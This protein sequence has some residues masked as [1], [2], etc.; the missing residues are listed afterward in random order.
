MTDQFQDSAEMEPGAKR[1]L[2][3]DDGAGR[4]PDGWKSVVGTFVGFVLLGRGLRR[5]SLRGVATALVGGALVY[6]TLS[7]DDR[8]EQALGIGTSEKTKSGKKAGIETETSVSRSITVGKSPDELYESWR[9]PEQFTRVMG[10][11]AD[12]TS[13]SDDRFYW[14]VHGPMGQDVSWETHVVDEEP[15]EF[16]QWKSPEDAMLPNEGEVRFEDAAGDRGTVVTLSVTIHPPGGALG[17][18]ALKR[19]GIVP[20]VLAGEA[21]RRFKS[22]AETGEIPS[23]SGNPSARGRGDLV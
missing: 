11:V 16:I 5:R 22:L 3:A 20:A 17:N 4:L 1:H 19:L 21:L 14:T 6:R 18:A 15:G 9:D 23:L 12:I 10:H 13:R 7:G 8:L 2:S